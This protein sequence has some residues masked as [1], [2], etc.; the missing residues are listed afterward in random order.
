MPV[1]QKVPGADELKELS[2][3]P[4]YVKLVEMSLRAF[5]Q[6]LKSGFLYQKS[7]NKKNPDFQIEGH[8]E[9]PVPG[10]QTFSMTILVQSMDAKKHKLQVNEQSMVS[11]SEKLRF[12]VHTIQPISIILQFTSG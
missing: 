8:I 9:L 7:A 6:K 11:L 5:R 12:A 2:R 4:G 3:E 1:Y 10:S